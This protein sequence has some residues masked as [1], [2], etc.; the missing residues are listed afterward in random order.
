VSIYPCDQCG[1]RVRGALNGAYLNTLRV[2]T[3]L[4]RRLR[5]CSPHLEE[6][7]SALEPYWDCI[8]YE[9]PPA[10]ANVCRACGTMVKRCSEL[11]LL[12]GNVYPKNAESDEYV[13]FLCD[14]C[15]KMVNTTW[16]LV[17]K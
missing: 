2:G 15:A 14:G 4:G 7:L 3:Q 10:E 16:G 5:L 11:T 8:D 12:T 17:P 6:L 13:G 1:H 9:T